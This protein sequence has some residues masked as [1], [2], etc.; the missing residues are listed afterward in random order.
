MTDDERRAFEK[1][2][3]HAGKAIKATLAAARAMGGEKAA[4]KIVDTISK[5]TEKKLREIIFQKKLTEEERDRAERLLERLREELAAIA[6]D[7][8]PW[9]ACPACGLAIV[10]ETT[11]GFR[12][13]R[14][15]TNPNRATCRAGHSWRMG[16]GAA[17]PPSSPLPR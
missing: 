16:D 4:R 2:L 5:E 12:A 15:E 3:E 11:M 14:P 6:R 10:E 13:S 9:E 1:L 7:R 17:W 8:P